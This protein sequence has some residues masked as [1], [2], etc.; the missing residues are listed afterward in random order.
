MKVLWD[1]LPS[2]ADF[3]FIGLH[4]GEGENGCVQGALEMLG[5]PYNGSSVLASSICMDKYKTDNT[6]KSQDFEVPLN[7][8]V[9]KKRGNMTQKQNLHRSLK[10]PP[11]PLLLNL[12]MM[13]AAFLCIKLSMKL[14]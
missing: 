7:Y 1:D 10:S 8:L 13:A 3:V 12:M 2:L 11:S 9:E 6:L 5:M 4:G 14:N